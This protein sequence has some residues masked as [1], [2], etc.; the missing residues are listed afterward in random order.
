VSLLSVAPGRTRV[1]RYRSRYLPLGV[2]VFVSRSSFLVYRSTRSGFTLSS[3]VED[4][5]SDDGDEQEQQVWNAVWRSLMKR[6]D[7]ASLKAELNH[8]ISPELAKKWACLH[9]W[10][11]CAQWE[12][13]GGPRQAPT[14]TIWANAGQ[15]KCCLRDKDRQL[16]LW[17]GADKL[18]Q[19]LDLADGLVLSPDAPWRIDQQDHERNGK[20][21]KKGS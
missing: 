3:I 13:G 4:F 17:L 15:W 14:V 7:P 9:E 19:L 6:P 12:D 21:V 1:V 18:I 16:V 20:R 11:T 10:L 5:E 8:A 2:V